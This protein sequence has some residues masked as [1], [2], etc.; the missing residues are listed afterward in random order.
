MA[1]TKNFLCP[2]EIENG[3]EMCIPHIGNGIGELIDINISEGEGGLDYL[4]G[5]CF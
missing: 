4:M 3:P 1:T 5:A 2:E